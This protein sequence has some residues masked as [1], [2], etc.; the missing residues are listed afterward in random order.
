MSQTKVP[1][2]SVF[3]LT[4]SMNDD[5]PTLMQK[6]QIANQVWG[7]AVPNACKRT[8]EHRLTS[9]W[10]Y[11][12]YI[13]R[14]RRWTMVLFRTQQTTDALSISRR[15]G[16]TGTGRHDVC[17][18]ATCEGTFLDD[19]QTKQGCSHY[20]IELFSSLVRPLLMVEWPYNLPFSS[21]FAGVA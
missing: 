13:D 20:S 11:L 2:Q 3:C 17:V 15:L 5:T 21:H 9:S 8:L 1:A 16:G 14:Q 6:G 4:L 19:K 7:R 10:S 18:R 12:T